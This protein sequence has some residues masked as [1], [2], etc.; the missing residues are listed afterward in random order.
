MHA[1]THGRMH[2]R[3]HAR[4]H[5]RTHARTHIHTH[6]HAHTHAHTHTWVLG[7]SQCAYFETV[8]IDGSKLSAD[9]A[10]FIHT[11]IA[12]VFQNTLIHMF[13]CFSFTFH[14]S[15]C[16]LHTQSTFQNPHVSSSF[17][18]VLPSRRYPVEPLLKNTSEIWT[19][20]LLNQDNGLFFFDFTISPLK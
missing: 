13:A 3:M 19:P 20:S 8:Y 15:R 12:T 7:V 5:T 2:A 16:L 14:L 9:F 11:N 1:R 4:T 6:T 17:N 18:H 10:S